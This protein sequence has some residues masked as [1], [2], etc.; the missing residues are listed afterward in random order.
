MMYKADKN[1]E[2]KKNQPDLDADEVRFLT[3]LTCLYPL[4]RTYRI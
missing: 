2:L 1:N 4:I 3:H